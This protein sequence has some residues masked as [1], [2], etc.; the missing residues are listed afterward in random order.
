MNQVIYCGPNW[1]K[2]GLQTFQ[3][4]INGLPSNVDDAIHECP[5]IRELIVNVDD[6][7]AFRVKLAK[8]NSRE[9]RLYARVK[10]AIK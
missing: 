6:L 8:V 5:E 3:V 1:I 4:F 9:S 2:H 10:E 7:D